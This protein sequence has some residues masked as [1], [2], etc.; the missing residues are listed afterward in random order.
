VTFSAAGLFAAVG[1]L[2]LS[3]FKKSRADGAIR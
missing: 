3:V 2:A 1:W